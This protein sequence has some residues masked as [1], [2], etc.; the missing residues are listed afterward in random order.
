[1]LAGVK[2]PRIADFLE[3]LCGNEKNGWQGGLLTHVDPAKRLLDP[4]TAHISEQSARHFA[5]SLG[6]EYTCLQKGTFSDHHEDKEFQLDRRDRFL[7]EYLDIYNNSPHLSQVEVAGGHHELVEN[8]KLEDI[9][10]RSHDITL[11]GGDGKTR[12]FDV[13][14]VFPETFRGRKCLL[15]S[16]DE[17]CFKAGEFEKAGWVKKGTQVCM[18]KSQGPSLHIADYLVE[19]GNGTI[20]LDP[21]GPAPFPIHISELR[22]WHSAWS[23]WKAA[24]SLSEKPTLPS[25]AAVYMYP[26]SG[27][28]KDG[29]WSSAEFWMQVDLAQEIF[30]AVFGSTEWKLVG[31]YDWSQGH[32]AKPQD[33]T[34]ATGMNVNPGGQQPHVRATSYPLVIRRDNTIM[35]RQL[36]CSPG[37]AECLVAARACSQADL[38]TFQ[39]IGRKGLKQVCIERGLWRPGMVQGEMVAALQTC[40]DFSAKRDWEKAYVTAQMAAAGNQALFGVKYHAELAAIERKWMYLK[41]MIRPYLDGKLKTLEELLRKHWAKFT[42]HDARKAARHC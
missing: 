41:R 10:L 20:C 42:V 13:G 37:C 7:P 23:T 18:D 6:F 31:V 25:T 16:H 2:A 14:G 26:G 15:A 17:S 12:T 35:P 5:L 39:S 3:F 27:R 30:K 21:A 38:A 8:D 22:K 24:P 33:A 34:D 29:W 36:L 28:G 32:A 9:A 40:E 11:V 19:W 4:G 1:M